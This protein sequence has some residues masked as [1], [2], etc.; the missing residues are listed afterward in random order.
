VRGPRGVRGGEERPQSGEGEGFS[1]AF[2]GTNRPS[3]QLGY[4]APPPEWK[5]T[6]PS[7]R[8]TRTIK[9]Y[10]KSLMFVWTLADPGHAGLGK[11]L[12]PGG[13]EP[14]TVPVHPAAA[15]P[16]AAQGHVLVGHGAA[17]AG[18]EVPLLG[19]RQGVWGP[20]LPHGPH[21]SVVSILCPPV[22][23]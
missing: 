1:K 23:T 8:S 21:R 7:N 19:G 20:R 15:R 11:L 3:P 5:D 16:V 22:E 10:K 4:R 6:L 17:A 12:V 9:K 13:A 2:Y 18:A 14:G